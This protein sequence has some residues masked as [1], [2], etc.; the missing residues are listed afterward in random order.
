MPH[1]LVPLQKHIFLEVVQEKD[2]RRNGEIRQV[3]SY[4]SSPLLL[5]SL[6]H[7]FGF[8]LPTP[9]QKNNFYKRVVVCEVL[10]R[11]DSI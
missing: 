2:K 11:V 4:L 3:F 6:L 1:I 9:T 7:V 10:L 5:K 8:F